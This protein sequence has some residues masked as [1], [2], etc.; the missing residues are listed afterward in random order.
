MS[1]PIKGKS[2]QGPRSSDTVEEGGGIQ[3]RLQ[4]RLEAQSIAECRKLDFGLGF[5]GGKGLLGCVL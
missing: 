4:R 3:A 1:G 5:Q 2:Y